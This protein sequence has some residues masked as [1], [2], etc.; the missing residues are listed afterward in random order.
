VVPQDSPERF[1]NQADVLLGR[2]N[3]A[4]DHEVFAVTRMRFPGDSVCPGLAHYQARRICDSCLDASS[5]LVQ[6]RARDFDLNRLAFY[7]LRYVE[8]RHHEL[9]EAD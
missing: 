1:A 6:V 9:T 7:P 8:R 5:V 2:A 3:Q 4:I